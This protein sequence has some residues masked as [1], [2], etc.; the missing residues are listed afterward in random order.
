[1]SL[2]TTKSGDRRPF[3]GEWRLVEMDLWDRDNLDLVGPARLVLDRHGHGSM[4][5]LAI[6]AGV[7]YRPGIRDGQPAVEF[8][9]EGSDEGDRISGRDRRFGGRSMAPGRP[10]RL[11]DSHSQPVSPLTG[12]RS[13]R[14]TIGSRDLE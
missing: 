10:H 9:F 8:S 14:G 1:M 13:R 3:I 4:R 5:F 7:D 12:D 2:M 6:E 11:R